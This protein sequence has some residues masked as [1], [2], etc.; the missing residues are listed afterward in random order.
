MARA[1]RNKAIETA[2]RNW[3]SD[4]V[5]SA[6]QI[7]HGVDSDGEDIIHITIELKPNAKPD[8]RKMVSLIRHLREQV[9]DQAF[10]LIEF[11]S[12]ADAKRRRA[13]A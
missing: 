5:V 10:P 13:A 11:M 7:A 8:R 6:V 9:T 4:A 2:V 1:D 3:L 12:P